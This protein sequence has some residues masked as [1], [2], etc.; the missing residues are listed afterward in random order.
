[1]PYFTVQCF[2]AFDS[3]DN[4]EDVEVPTFPT[5]ILNQLGRPAISNFVFVVFLSNSPSARS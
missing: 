1:M 4:G 5:A 3:K 2:E